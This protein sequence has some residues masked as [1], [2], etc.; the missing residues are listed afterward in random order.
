MRLSLFSECAICFLEEREE[1]THNTQQVH[2]VDARMI[3]L[4]NIKYE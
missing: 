4:F 2:I 3:L 1:N